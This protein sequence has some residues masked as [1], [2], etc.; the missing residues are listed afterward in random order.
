MSE[1]PHSL[2]FIALIYCANILHQSNIYCTVSFLHLHCRSPPPPNV[3]GSPLTSFYCTNLLCKSI[4]LWPFYTCPGVPPTTKFIVLD[5]IT[6]LFH[7]DL[8]VLVQGSPTN[9]IVLDFIA[10]LLHC[11]LFKTCTRYS[12]HHHLRSKWFI[13][14]LLCFYCTMTFLHLSKG[15]HYQFYCARIYCSFIVMSPFLHLSKDPPT[16]F[17]ALLL[18]CDLFALAL[19]VPRGHPTNFIV[20]DCIGLYCAFIA[21]WPFCTCTGG[22]PYHHLMSKRSPYQ[23]YCTRLYCAFIA[24]LLCCD[25][26]ALALEVLPTT[27]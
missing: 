6:F 11:D 23:F 8:F 24:L 13:A 15:P 4:V 2:V 16:N 21:L 3:R 20:P 25:L 7:C 1:G 26:F 22:S 19:E 12:P 17:I 5:F 10:L 9:F 14:L 18:H 27:T